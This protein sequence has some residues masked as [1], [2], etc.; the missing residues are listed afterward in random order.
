MLLISYHTKKSGLLL[1]DNWDVSE[2]CVTRPL[3]RDW[4]VISV[5][6]VQKFTLDVCVYV[7][8]VH[9]FF[10]LIVEFEENNYH[11][12]RHIFQVRKNALEMSS[13]FNDFFVL[14]FENSINNYFSLLIINNDFSLLIFFVE[15]F[16]NKDI[17]IPF[18]DVLKDRTCSLLQEFEGF[19]SL[20]H[21]NPITTKPPKLGKS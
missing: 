10:L 6:R 9:D 21:M 7:T 16:I 18:F 1:D 5:V 12:A 20:R 3:V 14:F 13:I 11:S 17:F 15:N 4:G 2:A 19:R 8:I